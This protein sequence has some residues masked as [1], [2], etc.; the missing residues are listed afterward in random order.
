MDIRCI[1][2]TGIENWFLTGD[3]NDQSIA[4]ITVE[5][6]SWFQEVLKGQDTYRTKRGRQGKRLF[7][8]STAATTESQQPLLNSNEPNVLWALQRTSHASPTA[9]VPG[10]PEG[11]MSM[12]VAFV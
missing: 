3:T 11:T 5:Q 10:L 1:I 2:I 6:I 7:F 9:P 4:D 8:Q 12:P